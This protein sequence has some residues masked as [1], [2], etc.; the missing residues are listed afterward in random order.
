MSWVDMFA[1]TV[2]G[3]AAL[4]CVIGRLAAMHVS[5]HRPSYLLGYFLAAGVCILAASMTWQQ[6][7]VCWLDWAAWGIGL[8][9]ALTWGDWRDGAPLEAYRGAPVR[10]GGGE[11]VPSTF[12]DGRR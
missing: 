6:L 11:L 4:E 10:A 1:F 5:E 7:D 3:A 2:A 8:H 9:L 12:D